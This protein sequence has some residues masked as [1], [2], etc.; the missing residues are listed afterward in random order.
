MLGELDD[1]RNLF[2]H[3]LAGKAD[4]FFFQKATSRVHPRF[5][6]G[7]TLQLLS[8]TNSKFDRRTDSVSLTIEDLRFYVAESRDILRA[9]AV[10]W[11]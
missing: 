1:L 8:G 3:N 11:P 7:V 10:A 9:L 5:Q 6:S 4:S 2:A